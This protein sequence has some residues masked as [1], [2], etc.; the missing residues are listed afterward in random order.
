MEK[1]KFPSPFGVSVFR[2][3]KGMYVKK[4]PPWLCAFTERMPL[5]VLV[6]VAR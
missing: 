2:K 4:L 5:T 3:L 1:S 6:E